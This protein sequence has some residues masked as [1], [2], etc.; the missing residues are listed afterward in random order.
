MTMPTSSHR[1][2]GASPANAGRLFSPEQ[3]DLFGRLEAPTIVAGTA[4]DLDIHFELLGALNTAIRHARVRGLSRPRI[5]DG[6]NRLLPEL[7]KPL[8]LRQINCWTA[9]SQ[10]EQHPF[11]TRYLPAFCRVV[12]D[13]GPLRVLAE[14]L[15]FALVDARDLEAKR[16]GEDLIK[17]AQLRRQIHQRQKKLGG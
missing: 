15:G 11:P 3:P 5:V 17:S 14:T 13:E 6:M 4:V 10:L 16:L 2:R 9:A 1:T 7:Q 12:D 8:T